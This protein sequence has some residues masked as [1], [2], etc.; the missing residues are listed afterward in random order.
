MVESRKL[1]YI[2]LQLV[3]SLPLL[4]VVAAIA[5]F[6][7]NNDGPELR[8][9]LLS[10]TTVEQLLKHSSQY[11]GK[12]VKVDGVVVGNFGIMGLGGFRLGDPA[13]GREIL[14]MTS[15]GVPQ[16]GNSILVLGRFRQTLSIGSRQ[17]AVIFMNF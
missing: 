11:D 12:I 16:V 8:A 14:V 9:I 15:S 2:T 5:Y 1:G 3:Y 7:S 4:A 6:I 13:S 17:Y 10:S